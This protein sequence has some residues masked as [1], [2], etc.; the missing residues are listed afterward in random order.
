MLYTQAIVPGQT[1]GSFM[2][3]RKKVL[4]LIVLVGFMAPAY[5]Q[6]ST[7][8]V[9]GTVRDQSSAVVPGA[10][11][12]LVNTD[13]NFRFETT[14]NSVGL[15][16]FPGI[17]S[18]PYKL[19]VSS[20]GMASFEARMLVQ[21]D[22]KVT[23]DPILR[24]ASTTEA[25]EV[26][27]VTPI[28]NLTDSTMSHVINN[29]QVDQLPRGDRTLLSLMVT[30]PG[31]ENGGL[32]SSGLRYGSTEFQ[33]DGT[34]LVS[35]SRGYLQYRQPGLDSI[36]EVSVDNN[37]VSAKYNSP[38]AVIASTKSGTNQFHGTLFET[39][40][41][42]RVGGA[43][44]RDAS[45]ASAPFANRGQYG[46]SFGGPV[47]IPK[48]YDGKN[49][50]FFFFSY[51]ATKR[52]A[53]A[54]VNYSVPTEAMRNGDF[55]S[56]VNTAG[57]KIAIY[58]PVTTDP[59]TFRR[60]QFSYSGKMNTIDPKRASP[61]WKSL[62]AITP[63]PTLPDVNPL[64][65]SNWFGNA[66]TVQDDWTNALRIDHRFSDRDIVYG[67]WSK[68]YI[69]SD[70]PFSGA[71]PLAATNAAN[72]SAYIAPGQSL[73]SSW[74]RNLSPT[75]FNE[76]LT[77]I[78]R[79]A[80][81]Q[82]SDP[83]ASVDF[84]AQLG[85]PNP[86]G[87]K[88]WPDILSLGLNGTLYRTVYPNRDHSTFY[89]VDDNVT[90]IV[91]KH[92]LLAGVHFRRDYVNYLPQQEQSAGLTQ[93]VANWTALWDP[94]G[95]INSPRTTPLT[96]SAI[97]ASY[98]GQM[99]YQVKTTHGYFYERENQ[100]AAYFQ[101]NYKIARRLSLNL[102]LRWQAWPALHEK[103]DNVTGF[104]LA[105][106]AVVLTQGFD[107]Y[108]KVNP[109][110]AQGIARLRALGVKFEDYKQAGLPQDLVRSNWKAFAPRVG[111]AYRATGGDKPMVVRGG[112]SMS[113]FPIPITGQLEKMRAGIPFVSTPLYSPDSTGYSP[114]A[115]SAYSLRN[116]PTY[117]AGLNT[118]R[119]LDN[120]M[121]TGGLT[122]G[123]L[124]ASLIDPNLP[125]ARVSDWNVTLEKEV[126][127]GTLTRV[128]WVGNHATNLDVFRN[129]NPQIS[130][131]AW[132]VNNGTP[133]PT[134][135]GVNRPYSSLY[136]DVIASGKY[137]YSNYTG[138]QLEIS[139]RYSRSYGY[140]LFYVVSNANALGAINDQGTST[141]TL[142]AA[143]FPASQVSGLSQSQLDRLL[144][145]RLDPSIP[146]QRVALNWVA[147]LPF[148][149]G[150][151]FGGNMNLVMNAMVGGWQISGYGT[152]ATS[153]FQIPA[154]Q[155]PTAGGKVEIYG[156]KYPIQDCRSGRCISGF[157]YYNGYMNPALIN[158]VDAKGNPNGIMGV[159]ANYKPAFQPLIPF[160]TMPVANDPNAPYYGTNT[161]FVP[162]NDGTVF[163]GAF[164]GIAPLQNQF[165]QSAGLWTLSASLFKVFPVKERLKLRVQWDV[166]NP[167]NTP[168]QPQTPSNS[169][170]LLYTNVSG[171]AARNMQFTLRASW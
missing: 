14:S 72:R 4:A 74:V 147:D 92:Q 81:Y 52:L 127:R 111:F 28:I 67:R 158:S 162:L 41:N 136:G 152:W 95:N 55:S 20:A 150:K 5:P 23:V 39:H 163:R 22:Q 83:S 135:A 123:S 161:A 140:Q 139:R 131:Y 143:A 54:L 61:L 96:G 115:K 171:T 73:A 104:D 19:T 119:V 9:S 133:Y 13:K 87:V 125:D 105:R 38:V 88:Q 142:P 44:T 33:L 32:R 101:D 17:I 75:L 167:T 58:D 43:R 31:V 30:V 97:A 42:S 91:G 120:A 86:L 53:N 149:K 169:L 78:Y 16:L 65:A 40:T 90:K 77:T 107:G 121:G 148:G 45:N 151:T 29:A 99:T 25:V 80:F 6:A 128:S 110:M 134:A 15:Y 12:A 103:Y 159:P 170:G 3:L 8:T 144:N 168:Q 34:P 164:G 84:D 59:D 10:R 141:T 160:P 66:K 165:V 154:D 114:D 98:L 62:M 18:G 24:A 50:T 63:L 49:K 35:R 124:T 93:P 21:A 37:N 130:Q 156:D 79:Q 109:S 126:L 102:G 108:Y 56:L 11:L 153:W 85:L 94:T 116:A 70:S 132:A 166:F 137:G 145:Y 26:S 71:V 68:N 7:S 146:K 106:Q 51:E 57:Q 48:V 100:Y 27:D 117:V 36:E 129:F 69:L 46:G 122:A 155:F 76:L 60:Q 118:T 82:N 138:M 64:L 157:L 112:F 47:W 1:G 89:Q 113:Y 2:G